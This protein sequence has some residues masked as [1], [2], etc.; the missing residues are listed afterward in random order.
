MTAKAGSCMAS[1][2]EAGPAGYAELHCLSNFSFL[3]G[4]SHPEEL[5]ERAQAQAYAALALTDECSLAGVVRAHKVAQA[6]GLKF[7]IGSEMRIAPDE[8][9][10]IAVNGLKLRAPVEALCLQAEEVTARPGA[11]GA[12]FEQA[13]V[14][15]GLA[16]CLE[17]LQAR[18]GAGAVRVLAGQADH[19]PECATGWREPDLDLPVSAASPASH[20]PP[21]PLWLLPAPQA[22]RE[23]RGR[24]YWQ[25]PLSLQSRAE[26]LESGWW[27]EGEAGA[28]GDLRRDY[29]VARNPHGQWAWV[30]RDSEGWFLHGL[31][32]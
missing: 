21:R 25:G 1:S 7:I 18:L 29:F 3:R 12:L 15:E 13:V 9:Q 19:R 8:A 24:P 2:P 20:P 6:A 17:R 26:R 22:L 31:F 30:F 32:A 28:A 23:E 27:D 16:L 5:V 10:P 14:G 4:A 11:S